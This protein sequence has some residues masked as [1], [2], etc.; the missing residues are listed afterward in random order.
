MTFKVD[1]PSW[2]KVQLIDH[3]GR[4]IEMIQDGELEIGEYTFETPIPSEVNDFGIIEVTVGDIV[5]T[6]K[7]IIQ[8]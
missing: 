3:A 2:V 5:S 4:A 6:E 8:K 1:Q 7:V